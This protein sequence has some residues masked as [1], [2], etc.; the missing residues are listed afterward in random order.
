MLHSLNQCINYLLELLLAFSLILQFLLGVRTLLMMKLIA[1]VLFT[2][3]GAL[4]VEFLIK[5]CVYFLLEQ[6]SF[7]VIVCTQSALLS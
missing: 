6:H 7:I 5:Q 2:R 3:I 4:L 1:T